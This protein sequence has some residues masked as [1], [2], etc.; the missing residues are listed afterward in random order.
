MHVYQV[1]K[2]LNDGEFSAVSQACIGA[3]TRLTDGAAV[4]V[5]PQLLLNMQNGGRVFHVAGGYLIAANK[6]RFRY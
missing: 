1:A 4:A 3:V 5:I 6:M 2:C